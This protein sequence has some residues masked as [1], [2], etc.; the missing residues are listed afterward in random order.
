MEKP[1]M[2]QTE[3][4]A[5][6]VIDRARAEFEAAKVKRDLLEAAVAAAYEKQQSAEVEHD[7]PKP[8]GRRPAPWHRLSQKMYGRLRA[9]LIGRF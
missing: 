5:R 6:E 7:W 2:Q 3:A 8:S 1:T 4:E 9:L